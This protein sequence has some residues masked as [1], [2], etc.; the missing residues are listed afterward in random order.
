MAEHSAEGCV[1]LPLAAPPGDGLGEAAELIGAQLVFLLD[2]AG[3]AP[4]WLHFP[5]VSF[6]LR[7][8][9]VIDELAIESPFPA[10]SEYFLFLEEFFKNALVSFLT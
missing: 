1:C 7:V 9:D 4:R 5:Q 10:S 2:P 6:L 8:L 3:L